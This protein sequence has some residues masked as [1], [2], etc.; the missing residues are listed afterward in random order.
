MSQVTTSEKTNEDE[1]CIQKDYHCSSCNLILGKMLYRQTTNGE[2]MFYHTGIINGIRFPR[3]C[4]WCGEEL[5]YSGA[6]NARPYV[7]SEG[8]GS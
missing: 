6:D 2:R 1:T 4:P 7:M 5:D 3:Y 8:E